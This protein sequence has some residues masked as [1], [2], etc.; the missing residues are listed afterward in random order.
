[1]LYDGK[2]MLEC[3]EQVGRYGSR[4]QMKSLTLERREGIPIFESRK[5]D[6]ENICL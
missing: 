5:G 2:E 4:S 3:V 6:G 1:M